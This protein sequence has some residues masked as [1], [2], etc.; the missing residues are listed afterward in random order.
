VIRSG[1]SSFGGGYVKNAIA[2]AAKAWVAAIT[3]AL[4]A[5]LP[6]IQEATNN[7]LATVVATVI[8]GGAVYLVPNKK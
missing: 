3:A 4:A 7:F 1:L 5:S 2:V 6:Q 8:A